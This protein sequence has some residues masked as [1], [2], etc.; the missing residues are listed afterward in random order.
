MGG[1]RGGGEGGVRE[2]GRGKGGKVTFQ[3]VPRKKLKPVE[4]KTETASCKK[5]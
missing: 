4:Q 5:L 1:G 2:W 3:R